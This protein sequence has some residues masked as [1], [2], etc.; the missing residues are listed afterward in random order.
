MEKVA[1]VRKQYIKKLPAIVHLDGSARVQTVVFKENPLFFKVLK[2]F[3]KISKFPIL[4]NTSLNV[5]GE[6]LAASPDDALTTF[7]NSGLDI[8]FLGNYLIKK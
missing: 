1:N 8:I 7:Y 4:L 3:E 6:P 2:E 5:N